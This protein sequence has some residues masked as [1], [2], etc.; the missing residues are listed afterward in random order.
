M[1]EMASFGPNGTENEDSLP[2]PPPVVPSDVVPVKAEPEKKKA[3][4]F[5][6]ARRGLASK[7]TKLQLLTNHYRVNVANTDGHF[8]QY[9][10][11]AFIFTSIIYFRSLFNLES[12]IQCLCLSR[13]LFFMMMDDLWRVRV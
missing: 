10:V 7:G 13:L 9:S 6:I 11:C 12:F 1:Q 2:P 8:Y 5:P 4:R 3:S